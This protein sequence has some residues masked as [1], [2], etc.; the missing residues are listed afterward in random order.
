MSENPLARHGHLA[1]LHVPA[2]DLRRSAS[3]Y[4]DV[5][6]WHIDE[7]GPN[8]IRFADGAGL[9]IG[10]FV[11]DS[12]PAREPGFLPYFYVVGLD[13]ALAKIAAHGA[14][15]VE[16]ARPEGDLR[17]ARVRD[18]AGNLVGLWQFA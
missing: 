13:A 18:P 11:T 3:F 6:G 15:I 12:V 16:P 8:D 1:Y 17:L 10:R 14:D 7:R 4:A 2:T 9:L 5:L